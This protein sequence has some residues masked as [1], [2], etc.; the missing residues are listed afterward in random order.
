M[1]KDTGYGVVAPDLLGYCNT[2]RLEELEAY[3]MKR[4][5]GYMVDFPEK[6]GLEKVVGVAH[7]WGLGFWR[8]SLPTI[9]NASSVR[10]LS[11]L[12]ISSL[13]SFMI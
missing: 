1:L 4:M 8:V 2:D 9:P 13:G 7:D 5:R 11:V 12:A 3:S 10:S 6:E